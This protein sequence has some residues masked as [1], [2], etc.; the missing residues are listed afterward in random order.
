MIFYLIVSN[1]QFARLRSQ[2]A[3]LLSFKGLSTEQRS[4]NQY[5]PSALP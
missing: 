4:S 5:L 3:T 1:G 2:L